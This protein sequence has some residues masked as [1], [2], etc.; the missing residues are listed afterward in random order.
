VS[1]FSSGTIFA[2]EVWGITWKKGRGI[3]D[4]KLG[5]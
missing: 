2:V 3:P 1:R 5:D 4:G